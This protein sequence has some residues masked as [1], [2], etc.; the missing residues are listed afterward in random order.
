MRRWRLVIGVNVIAQQY[1]I[2][3][4]VVKGGARKESLAL[5]QRQSYS[6]NRHT[7]TAGRDSGHQTCSRGALDRLRSCCMPQ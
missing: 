1:L 7:R 4:G 6:Q 2:I 3:V 5:E